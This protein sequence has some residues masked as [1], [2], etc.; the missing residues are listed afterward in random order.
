MVSIGLLTYGKTTTCSAVVR[1]YD[2][3]NI[4]GISY[5]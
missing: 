2:M 3:I 4:N 1:V 5:L